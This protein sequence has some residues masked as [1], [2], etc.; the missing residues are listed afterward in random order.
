M[1]HIKQKSN[2]KLAANSRIEALQLRDAP[3]VAITISSNSINVSFDRRWES[4]TIEISS[5][6]SMVEVDRNPM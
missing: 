4:I 6:S 2:T 5:V 1:R 3:L